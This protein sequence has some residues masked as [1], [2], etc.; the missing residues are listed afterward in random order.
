MRFYLPFLL[1]L[2]QVSSAEEDNQVNFIE[3]EDRLQIRIGDELF[4]EYR[5]SGEDRFFPTFYPVFAPGQ[6]PMT[7]AFPFE[8]TGL[9]DTD[10][11]HHQSIWFAHSNINGET[12]W[13]V[14]EYRGRK[15]GRTVHQGFRSME[16]GET[17]GTFVAE[18]N[19]VASDGTIVLSDTRTVSI[20]QSGPTRI[21]DMKIEFHASHGPVLFGDE[22]DAGMAIRVASELQIERRNKALKDSIQNSA[23]LKNS[24]GDSGKATWGKKAKWIRSSGVIS[25]TPVAIT[26][27]DH[28]DNPRHPTSWHSRT[29]GLISANIFGTHFFEKTDD[30]NSGAYQIPEGEKRTFQWRFHIS[31]NE[32]GEQDPASHFN[33]YSQTSK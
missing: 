8:D 4:T 12:F 6:I 17:S 18:N 3:L 29:Y 14:K 13:A 1:F 10:H 22:K 30:R 5:F 11:P 25:D 33:D 32:E 23:T 16:S 21:L 31:N 7:R 9:D 20:S 28:P 24:E 2:L 27:L 15:P 26:I 19:Y